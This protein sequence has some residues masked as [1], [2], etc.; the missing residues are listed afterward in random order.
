MP[1]QIT[2]IGLGQIGGSIG[3]ALED[4]KA[5]IHRVGFDK[6]AGVAKAAESLGVVDEIKGLIAA[7]READIVMLC[8]PLGEL[9]TTLQKIGFQLKKNT[10]VVDTAP[11]KS[12]MVEWT[13]NLLPAERFYIGLVPAVT[14]E[15]LATAETGFKAARPDLFKNTVMIVDAPPGT[16]AEVEQLAINLVRILG[17]KPMLTDIAE[18]DGLMTSVHVLPQL[19]AAALLDATVDRPGWLEAR[20]LAGRPFTG[21]TGGL[22]YHDDPASLQVAALANRPVVMHALDAM[23]ASLKD[24]RD[25]IERGDEKGLADRLK[26]AFESRETWLDERGAAEWLKEGG[27]TLELPELGE[28]ILQSLFGNRIIDRNKKKK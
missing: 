28:Q 17:A 24:L 5:S 9:R 18:S 19:T 8:L 10:V 21:V 27:D 3:M 14:T 11:L 23:I 4:R 26:Q 22:A 13:K 7:V 2:I 16:P 25:D 1:T 12:P 15:A 20:K 6:D